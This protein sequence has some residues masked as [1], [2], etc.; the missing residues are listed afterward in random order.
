[1]IQSRKL[2]L[3]ILLAIA[4]VLLAVSV[5][6]WHQNRDLE[7]V[8]KAEPLNTAIWAGDLSKITVLIAEDRSILRAEGVK[9]TTPLNSA[10]RAGR[11]EVVELLLVNGARD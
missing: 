11:R 2:P 9:N 3:V 6:L 1:M 8:G 4:G 7:L 5:R 10:V